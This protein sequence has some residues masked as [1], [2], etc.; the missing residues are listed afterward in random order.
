MKFGKDQIRCELIQY[1][2]PDD[3][4]KDWNLNHHYNPLLSGVRQAY[5]QTAIVGPKIIPSQKSLIQISFLPFVLFFRFTSRWL[6][7]GVEVLFNKIM[8]IPHV[9]CV[10]TTA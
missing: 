4:K 7:V 5:C 9:L 1:D 8:L 3:G 6:L 2:P 10:D